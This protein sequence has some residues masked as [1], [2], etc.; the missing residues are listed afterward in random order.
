[1]SVAA[2]GYIRRVHAMIGDLLGPREGICLDVCCGTGAHAAALAR[3]GWTPVGVDLS[4]GQLRH[5]G[6]RLPVAVA[7]S[8]ALPFPD[9]CLP[10]AACVLASTDVPDY[11]AVLR[12]ISRVL[13]PGSRFIHVAM[14]GRPAMPLAE[15]IKKATMRGQPKGMFQ[16]FTDRARRVVCLAQEEA[17]LLGHNYV[18]TEHLLL[19]LLHAGEGVAAGA[20]A[21]QGISLHDVRGQVEQFIGHGPRPVTGAIPFTPRTK[22]VLELSLREELAPGHHHIGTEHLLL[23][24]LREG[25]GVGARVLTRL[26]ADHAQVR[27]Q[28]LGLLNRES[29]Q[30]DLQAQLAVD[31]AGTAEQLDHLRRDKEAAFGAGDLDRAAPLRDQEKQLLAARLPLESQLT[32]GAAGQAIFAE[33]QRLHRDLER[34]RDQLRQHGIDPDNGTARTA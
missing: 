5:A 33:N 20:L 22:K 17:R 21:A 24:L 6:A 1:M 29:E 2:G 3:L 14:R 18:G 7:D 10:A 34:L 32:A 13:R 8:T 11:A 27:E 31:L 4:A 25:Q 9:H 30:Q 23:A 19:G 16:R 28:V 15:R 12:E 26:G